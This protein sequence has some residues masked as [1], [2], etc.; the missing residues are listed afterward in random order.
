M[1]LTGRQLWRWG[2]CCCHYRPYWQLQNQ[3]T[4]RTLWWPI[5]WEEHWVSMSVCERGRVC[6]IS[7]PLF[8]DLT[9]CSLSKCDLLNCHLVR[10]LCCCLAA[11]S[12]LWCVLYFFL[13]FFSLFLSLS[14]QY[15]QNPEM[16]KQTARLW[17]HVYAGAP[18]SSPE[19][20]RKIDKLCAMGFDKVSGPPV[21]SSNA[22]SA[23]D[24]FITH[25]H[26]IMV[27]QWICF[28]WIL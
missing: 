2:Q 12:V 9:I 19:Y 28:V 4:H 23:V 15:K 18:S 17:S 25:L 26:F 22:V 3:M 10:F 16:F 8:V 13:S 27:H 24:T 7:M 5:R 6:I 1:C 11:C 14:P 20:T 21:T